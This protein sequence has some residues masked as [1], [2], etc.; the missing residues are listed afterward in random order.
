MPALPPAANHTKVIVT[1]AHQEDAHVQNSFYLNVPGG[2]SAADAN[3][4]AQDIFN[5][6]GATF[7]PAKVN[8]C[9]LDSVEVVDLTSN[10]GAVGFHTG[11]VNGGNVSAPLPAATAAIFEFHIARRYRGGKPKLFMSGY[12]INQITDAQSWVAGFTA[13]R[14]GEWVAFIAALIAGAPAGATP[15]GQANVSYFQGFN[16]VISPT[17]GRARNVPKLRVG[18]PVFDPIESITVKPTFGFQKRRG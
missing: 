13:A 12:G 14:V 16:V 3:A 2:Y 10:T 8:V 6:W 9:T 18:G 15:I 17:T 1:E 11:T 7:M 4:L 5:E